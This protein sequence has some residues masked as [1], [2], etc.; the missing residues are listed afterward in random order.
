M[1]GAEAIEVV[2]LVAE[3]GR[4]RVGAG[5][6]VDELA[7]VTVRV[8]VRVKVKVRVRVRVRSPNPNPNP[9]NPNPNLGGH[10]GPQ[11]GHREQ[12]EDEEDGLA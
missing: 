6:H 10:V 2:D 8:R 5:D 3:D 9:P 7:R 11:R 1:E 4:V 12:E